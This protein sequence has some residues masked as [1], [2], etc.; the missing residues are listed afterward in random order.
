MTTDRE[1]AKAILESLADSGVSHEL[2]PRGQTRDCPSIP[3]VANVSQGRLAA[4]LSWHVAGCR[5]CAAAVRGV[6]ASI[7]EL[8][9]EWAIVERVSDDLRSGRQ[10]HAVHLDRAVFTVLSTAPLISEGALAP[11]LRSGVA[12]AA[13]VL[14]TRTSTGSDVSDDLRLVA[15]SLRS[16][17]PHYR[18]PETSEPFAPT[19]VA[20]LRKRAHTAAKT[21]DHS[22]AALMYL[23][24]GARL[25]AG[26]CHLAVGLQSAEQ[27]SVDD[28]ATALAL[29]RL[30]LAGT[31]E[32][33]DVA[34]ALGR[35]AAAS[36]RNDLAGPYL[37]EAWNGYKDSGESAHAESLRA[38]IDQLPT[39]DV[40]PGGHLP[41][42]V[43]SRKANVQSDRESTR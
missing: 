8:G 35:L 22:A 43:V 15:F 23:S 21:G 17:G 4:G 39:T 16:G 3:V 28:A 6:W 26:R 41:E 9:G 7:D 13:E 37:V 12:A 30:E 14:A 5:Y 20:F 2:L 38:E 18:A 29:A 1:I 10:S 19:M 36:G 42:D 27:R 32:E 24:A 11:Y 40:S 34:T 33:L 31:P 25:E